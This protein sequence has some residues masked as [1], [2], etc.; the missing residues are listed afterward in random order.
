MPESNVTVTSAAGVPA[1]QL[2]AQARL[3]LEHAGQWVAW[4]EDFTRVVASG[5]SFE[6][7]RD[8]VRRLG[9]MLT[10]SEWIPPVPVQ[11]LDG[12]V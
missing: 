6:A 4:S 3:R 7:M 5:D 12:D 9:V 2:P 1:S 10:V 8:A 11:P